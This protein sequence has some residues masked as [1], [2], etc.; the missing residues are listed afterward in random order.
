MPEEFGKKSRQLAFGK[1]SWDKR[2][3]LIVDAALCD[4]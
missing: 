4:L 2:A 3:K 1:Y